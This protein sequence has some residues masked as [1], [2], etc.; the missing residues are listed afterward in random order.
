MRFGYFTLSDN[1]YRENTRAPNQFV[2]DIIDEAIYR[3]R[4]RPAFRLDRRAPFQHLGRAVLSRHRVGLHR[5]AHTAHPAGAR[6]HRSAA[7][8]PD[9]RRRA[10]GD[11]RSAVGRAR[12]F[13]HRPRLR[14]A[15]NTCRWA[16]RSTTTNRSSKRAWRWCAACGRPTG[17]SRITAGTMRS[18]TWRSR[19]SR[20]S[21]RS[22]LMSRS[23]SRA[24][25]RAGG[26]AW[27]RVD[28]GAVRR[29][30]DASAACVR[31]RS[32]ISETCAKH[33]TTPG[34][35]M[36]SYFIHFAD[37]P[38]EEAAARAR[39]V[40]YYRE[41]V[42]PA[43]PG[44]PA[45]APPSYR[46]FIDMVAAAADR[47]AGRPDARTPVLLGSPAA[48]HRDVAA[49]RSG[50]VRRGDPLFQRWP[51]AARAGQRRDGAVH[52]GSGAGVCADASHARLS[53]CPFQRHGR[54]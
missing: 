6:R 17:R 12:R 46:Y 15:A 22:R 21:G 1:A 37:T 13:R 34:R 31:W 33:G 7:A 43:F 27:V 2:A 16:C 4:D 18:T 51:E 24:F 49:G 5:G 19:R 9:P 50:G 25:Y 3:R 36:C 40:R 29:G 32:F 42:I 11:A 53:H 39:Q 10:M 38:A 8:S 47:E 26:A 35:L 41:C 28:R 48:D 54:A 23:F 20:C 44:D 14:P 52:D 30:D 45:T